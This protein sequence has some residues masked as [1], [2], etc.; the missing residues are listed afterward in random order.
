MIHLGFEGGLWLWCLLGSTCIWVVPQIRG[1]VPGVVVEGERALGEL[2]KA[3]DIN[4]VSLD[5]C[6]SSLR[7]AVVAG[8]HR[9]SR[10]AGIWAPCSS[11]SEEA[12]GFSGVHGRH[13]SPFTRSLGVGSLRA[14]IQYERPG[15]GNSSTQTC[16]AMWVGPGVRGEGHEQERLAQDSLVL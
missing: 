1:Q 16:G 9:A 5:F 4:A 12:I 10:G 13:G 14:G 15:I 8:D 3:R 2:A 11:L 7:S 6:L